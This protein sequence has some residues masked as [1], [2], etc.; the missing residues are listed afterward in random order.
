[1]IQTFSSCKKYKIFYVSIYTYVYIYTHI[2]N[3]FIDIFK[4]FPH[5]CKKPGKALARSHFV[6]LVHLSEG[7]WQGMAGAKW[8]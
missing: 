4:C 8:L 2:S 7:A 3:L 6:D 1:M 5:F